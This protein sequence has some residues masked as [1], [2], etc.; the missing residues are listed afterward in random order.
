V[1]ALLGPG[2][3]RVWLSSEGFRIAADNVQKQVRVDVQRGGGYT[4]GVRL[5][6]L[7]LRPKVGSARFDRPG[8]R[9]KGL[10]G[11]GARLNLRVMGTSRDGLR[12]LSVT[13]QGPG[14]APAGSGALGL[15]VDRH[16][17][18]SR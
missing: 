16:G 10:N 8:P 6:V 4:G 3:L 7:G 17:P 18:K 1:G 11:L 9:L 12:Q 14:G 5:K 2:E 15:L 13:A